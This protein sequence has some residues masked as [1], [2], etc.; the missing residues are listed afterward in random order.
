MLLIVRIAAVVFAGISALPLLLPGVR[1][2]LLVLVGGYLA[3]FF[4]S[5]DAQ[6]ALKQHRPM[7][8]RQ[9]W[10]FAGAIVAGCLVSV[11]SAWIMSELP[12]IDTGIRDT[13]IFAALLPVV[14]AITLGLIALF[15]V[16][17]RFPKAPVAAPAPVALQPVNAP[18]APATP[19]APQ[20]AAADTPKKPEVT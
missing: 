14:V 9:A 13:G 7:P 18:S 19:P 4:L 15:V 16:I 1:G 8:A 11:L 3:F 12:G 17:Q 5:K 20:P 2:V 6:K 10:C